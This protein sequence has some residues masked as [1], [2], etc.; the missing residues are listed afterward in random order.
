MQIKQFI[1]ITITTTTTTTTWGNSSPNP[2]WPRI[3]TSLGLKL[4]LDALHG[5]RSRS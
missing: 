5:P 2:K 1:T 4:T 3:L